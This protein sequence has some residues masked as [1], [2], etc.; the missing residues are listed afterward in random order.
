[1]TKGLVHQHWLGKLRRRTL[2]HS[3]NM[4]RLS[5]RHNRQGVVHRR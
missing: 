4:L 3:R 2:R 1:M 5:N